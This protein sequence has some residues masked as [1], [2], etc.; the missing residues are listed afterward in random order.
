MAEADEARVAADERDVRGL[1]GDVRARADGDADVGLRERRRVVD[2]VARPWPRRALAP[3]A[4][5]RGRPC[6]PGSTPADDVASMP[7]RRAT[8]RGGLALSPLSEPDLDAERRAARRT[9]SAAAGLDRV[10]DADATDERC[11]RA[12][13][14]PASGPPA[15]RVAG[16][17]RAASAVASTPSSARKAALPDE[18]A[19]VVRRVARD[20]PARSP[21]RRRRG[22]VEGQAAALGLGDDG[23]G[24]ADARSRA[25]RRPPGATTSSSRRAGAARDRGHR[26]AAQR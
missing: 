19:P 18:D 3:G 12:P 23:R 1:D 7:T 22:L 10:V 14:G 13:R 25:R 8:A 2:A 20:A 17:G 24:R 5:G 6:R 16:G 4:R 21:T 26:R 9:A 11:R 15:R